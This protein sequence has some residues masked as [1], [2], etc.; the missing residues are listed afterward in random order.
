[1]RRRQSVCSEAAIAM[2]CSGNLGS[3][4]LDH[5]EPVRWLFPARV[6]TAGQPW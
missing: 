3:L 6:M 2:C 5:A 4:G 1:M